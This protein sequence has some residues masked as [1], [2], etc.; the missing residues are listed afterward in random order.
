MRTTIFERKNSD[1]H[2]FPLI[3]RLKHT[4]TSFNSTSSFMPRYYLYN[5]ETLLASKAILLYSCA[6][7]DKQKK[8]N[9]NVY[10]L[11]NI[12]QT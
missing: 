8:I 4:P 11:R 6:T 12:A 1:G 3:K 10:R 2:L 5:R 9:N 7:V